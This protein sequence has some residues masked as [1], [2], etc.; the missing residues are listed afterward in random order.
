MLAVFMVIIGYVWPVFIRGRGDCGAA[1]A[2]VGV[3]GDSAS[4]GGS[5]GG[6]GLSASIFFKS[7]TKP[8]P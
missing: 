3:A 8:W 5:N 6:P 7:A 1:T 4:G 2:V